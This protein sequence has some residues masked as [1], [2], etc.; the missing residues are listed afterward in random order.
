MTDCPRLAEVERARERRAPD[1]AL[2]EHARGCPQCGALARIAPALATLPVPERDPFAIPRERHRLLL[3][4]EQGLVPAARRW[5]SARAVV[6][7]VGAAAGLAVLATWL[8][9][10]DAPAV[11]P[12]T[13]D[14]TDARWSRSDEAGTTVVHLEE[15]E[16][17]LHVAH[18]A[19]PHRLVVSLPDGELD[20][21]GT[22]FVVRVAHGQTTAVAV[23]EGAVVLRVVGKPPVF[24]VAGEHWPV[25]PRVVIAPVV[26]PVVPPVVRDGPAPRPTPV[27]PP[28]PSSPASTVRIADEYRAAVRR[29]DEGDL[30]AAVTALRSFVARHPD[31]H[32]A[33]DASYLLVLAL[34]RAGA[35][36]QARDAARAYLAQYPR[37]F[38]RAAVEPIAR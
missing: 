14:A 37:G 32:H 6:A 28:R 33:E 19:E 18:G 26:P 30:P 31:D 17:A 3:A 27:A 13:V 10:R 9:H 4:F 25:A 1:A 11:N 35:N 8:V 15:G 16:L 20:D 24:L 12:V 34:Q 5:W 23:R 21:L 38:Q 36:D 29:F 7:L 2:V 22:T